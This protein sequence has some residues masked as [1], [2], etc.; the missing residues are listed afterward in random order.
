VA[1]QAALLDRNSQRG[2]VDRDEGGAFALV[3]CGPCSRLQ[4]QTRTPRGL[5]QRRNAAPQITSQWVARAAALRHTG[6]ATTP[7]WRVDERSTW[8]LGR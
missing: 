3:H 8:E 6:Y 1:C 7:Q 2:F 5:R 4:R